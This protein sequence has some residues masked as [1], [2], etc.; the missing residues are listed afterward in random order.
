MARIQIQYWDD[1]NGVPAVINPNADE[2]DVRGVYIQTDSSDDET[3]AI[4]RDASNNLKF[5]DGTVEGEKSLAD[6][7]AGG[8][9][10]DRLLITTAG[11]IVYDNSGVIVVKS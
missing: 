1:A 8:F 10:I 4:T 3:V 7:I 9:D 5:K 6:L 11:G 2:L